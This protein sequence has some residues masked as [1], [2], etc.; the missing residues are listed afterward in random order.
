[1]LEKE[2]ET[3]I[4]QFLHYNHIYCWKNQSVGIFDPV[5]KI[6]RKSN[7]KYHINGV[8][9][10]LGILPDGKFLGIEVKTKTGKLSDNQKAFLEK[11]SHLNSICF[12]ARSIEEVSAK[13]SPYL[14]S[15]I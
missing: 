13:L 8:P 14:K 1:M 7:N 2:I 6:Y 11:A 3:Q 4:L 15:R 10:I 5:K 9:D 12:V